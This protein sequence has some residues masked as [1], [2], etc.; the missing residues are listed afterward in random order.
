MDLPIF[1]IHGSNDC[2]SNTGE[3][4]SPLDLL[5]A[6][7][8]VSKCKLSNIIFVNI[9]KILNK[10]F[11]MRHLKSIVIEDVVRS[12]YWK[13]NKENELVIAG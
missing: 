13:E 1:S 11:D 12:S 6:S 7:S 10:V 8:L 4:I 9:I 3:N 5:Q 2:P